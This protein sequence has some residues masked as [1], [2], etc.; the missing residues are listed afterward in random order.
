MKNISVVKIFNVL[1]LFIFFTGIFML[2]PVLVDLSRKEETYII[3]LIFS[4]LS[5][6]VGGS[7]YLATYEKS[8]TVNYKEGVLL[9]VF[10]W[11]IIV[12]FAALPIQYASEDINYVDA[13]FEAM[14]GITTTGATVF[15]NLSELSLGMHLWRA[16]IQW[17]GG[18][19]IVVTGLAILPNLKIGGM[20]MF[21]I[22]SFDIDQSS[23]KAT[24]L[25]SSIMKI[26]TLLTIII[27]LLLWLV[28]KLSF[29]DSIIHAFTSISTAGFSNYDASIGFF[30]NPTAEVI[31]TISM[32]VGG[33]PLILV[34]FLVFEGKIKN[35]FKDQQIKGFL[36]AIL[37]I[38]MVV[39]AYLV[40]KNGFSIGQSLRY[41]SFTVVSIITGTGYVLTDYTTWGTSIV[42]LLFIITFSGGC[43]GG[44]SCGIKIFRFQILTSFTLAKL[45]QN[46][47]HKSVITPYYNKRPLNDNIV[48]SVVVYFY[49]FIV[50]FIAIS[51]VLTFFGLDII[52]ATSATATSLA[53]VGPG[54]GDVIGPSG[55]FSSLQ[56]S[57]KIILIFAMIIGRL[58]I[59]GLYMMIYKSFW[60]NK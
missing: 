56:S 41:A 24:S 31:L 5:I 52:T 17:V 11:F 6:V 51:F 39:T 14:S 23:N 49:F 25:A 57:V 34:Y 53:N 40:I 47:I 1:G 9:T 27:I 44:T 12:A 45:K 46:N 19:G 43:S 54:F 38:V 18:L 58:E 10:S 16:L 55:N 36:I 22:E 37:T 2:I 60:Q 59:I 7:I 42:M 8:S 35:F 4:I 48:N 13:Y 32:I 28:A 26:Y 30:N 29:F 21:K 3:F 33:M 20:Q 50:T 15:A